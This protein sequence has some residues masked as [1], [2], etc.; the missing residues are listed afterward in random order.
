MPVEEDMTAAGVLSHMSCVPC[1]L[2]ALSGRPLLY[3]AHPGTEDTMD[4]THSQYVVSLTISVA[5][6]YGYLTRTLTL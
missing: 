5:Q 1:R 6:S 2:C 3:R 4:H